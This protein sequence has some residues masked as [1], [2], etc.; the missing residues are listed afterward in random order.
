MSND[1]W[2]LPTRYLAFILLLVFS[3]WLLYVARSVVTALV[4]SALIAY[5]LSPLVNLLRVR[6]PRRLAVSLIYVIFLAVLVVAPLLFAPWIVRQ[7][8]SFEAELLRLQ[9]DVESFLGR[10][11]LLGLPFPASLP[12]LDIQAALADLLHPTQLLAIF[13][14]VSA[15][16]VYVLIALVSIYYFLLDAERLRDW[17][18]D[19]FPAAEHSDVQRLY[20]RIR[21]VWGAYLRGQLIL[22]FF[23]GLLTGLAMAVVG[24]PGAAFVGLL[25]GLLDII[26][27]LGPA[28]AACVA[29]LVAIFEGSLFLRLDPLSYAILVS[30]IFIAIQTLENVWLRPRLM[31]TRL[32]LHPLLVFIG[33]IGALALSGILA[34]LIIVPVMSSVAIIGHYLWRRILGLDPW[35]E[36]VELLETDLEPVD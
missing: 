13:Q 34:A 24:L 36:A 1:S 4:V 31:G 14:I 3:G 33:V 11:E 22:M 30:V 18:I 23:V 20:E 9:G 16:L 25:A 29:I 2:N 7:A 32:H 28:I 26:P 8:G 21:L 27:S 10:L 6:L 35:V 17:I 5:A 15:N 12:P 19:L